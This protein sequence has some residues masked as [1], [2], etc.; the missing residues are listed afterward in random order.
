[1]RCY[2]YWLLFFTVNVVFSQE[3]TYPAPMIAV[4]SLYRED[5]FYLAI[6]YNSLLN[7][8]DGISQKKFSSGFKAGFLRDFPINKKRNVA[9]ATGLGLSFNKY[10]Q[11][12]IIS[13]VNGVAVYNTPENGI[14]Y[15]KNKF[16]QLFVDVPIEYRWR[17]SVPET[18][19]FWRIYTGLQLSYLAYNKSV[20]VDDL[21]HINVSNNRDFNKFQAGLYVAAG[22]NTWNFYGYYGLLPIFKSSAKVNK[23]EIGLHTFNV[24]LM[25]YIL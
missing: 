4:D 19:K 6:T 24:G 15:S 17:T 11:K 12:L 13:K 14:D 3:L 5:Q 21:Y 1:M 10:F 18:H 9:I 2:C 25:F 16:E 23:Q 7:A 20:Y 22:Y 8:P